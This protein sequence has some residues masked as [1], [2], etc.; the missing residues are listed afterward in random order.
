MADNFT[1]LIA[2]VRSF[3]PDRDGGFIDDTDI[4]NY[5]N[6]AYFDLADRLEAVEQTFT[7]T[8]TGDTIAM[9][10]SGSAVIG[11]V[12]SLRID[13]EDVAFVDDATWN[14]FADATSDPDFTI[15]RVFDGNIELFPDPGTG[16]DY[17]LRCLI[18]PAAMSGSDTHE[19]PIWIERKLIDWATYRG[20]MKGD[21]IYRGREFLSMYLEGLPEPSYGK[22]RGIPGPLTLAPS[23]GPF[24]L[25][26]DAAHI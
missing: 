16:L 24:D 20:C 22:D 2:R 9:P 23:V 3:L 8:T 21:E 4:A 10:P 7:A 26:V 5:L 13:D 11:R 17:D 15:A 12:T 25:D 1:T 19:L 14:S 6:E 18:I